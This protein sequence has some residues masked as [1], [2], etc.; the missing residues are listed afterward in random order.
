MKTVCHK[1]P[2]FESLFNKEIVADF[3]GGHITSDGGSLLLRE[4]DK[5]YRI[6][7]AIT[8]SLYDQ[9]RPERITH[10]LLTIVRQR[11]MS[12]AMG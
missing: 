7:Q 5:T 8:S 9:R 10:D 1:Q 12:I 11:V 4:L 2:R 6:S 3:D